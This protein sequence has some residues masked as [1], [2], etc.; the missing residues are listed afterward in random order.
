MEGDSG[1]LVK[2]KNLS[3]SEWDDYALLDS[4][5]GKKIERFG[6]KLIIRHE[7][8]AIWKP[9]NPN[10]WKEADAIYAIGKKVEGW[11][12]RSR[13]NPVWRI[14]LDNFI[15][16]LEIKNSQ[17]IGIF[18]EQ[19]QNWRWIEKTIKASNKQLRILNLFGYSGIATAYALRAGAHTTHVDASKRAIQSA[20][21]NIALCN[22]NHKPARWLVDDAMKFVEKEIHRGNT[23]DGLI[24][25]PPIFGRGPKGEIWHFEKDIHQLLE[26]CRKIMNTDMRFFILTAYNIP[27]NAN[28]LKDLVLSVWK[29]DM[30]TF[31]YGDLSQVEKSAGRVI[32]QAI[33]IRWT[34]K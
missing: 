24:L 8:A 9:L 33:Y 32:Q 12:F 19:V 23:Y 14:K 5:N 11:E 22:L 27:Q 18:P 7:P 16:Q 1:L 34:A 20:R 6:T 4:G 31:T 2:E 28:E 15:F 26:N 13:A 30:G 3:I 21:K 25:D 17:H 10:I 29:F